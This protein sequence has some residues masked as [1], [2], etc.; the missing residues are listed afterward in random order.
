MAEA[1]PTST[2]IT[3]YVVEHFEEEFSDWTFSEYAHMVLSLNKLY[4][5]AAEAPTPS[6]TVHKEVLVLTNFPFIA[7]LARNELEEDELH[8]KRNTERF[9]QLI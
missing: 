7:K 9:L 8:T 4:D 1:A 2:I 5:Q 6:A 3:H